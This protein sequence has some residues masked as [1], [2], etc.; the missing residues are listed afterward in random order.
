MRMP[1]PTRRDVMIGALG[2]G[3]VAMPAR[4][5]AAWVPSRAVTVF[6]PFAAGSGTDQVARILQKAMEDVWPQRLVVE[7][8]PGAN[9]S[10]AALATAR[11]AP[12]GHTLMVTTNTPHAA[13]KALMKRLDYDPLAD[14]TPITRLGNYLFWLAVGPQF[15]AR[16]FQEFLTELR[17]RPGQVTYA[18]GNSTGIV[19]SATIARM[20]GVEMVHVPYR[21]TPPAM[22]DVIAGRVD[23]MVVDVAASRGHVEAGRLIPIGMTTR[24]RSRLLPAVPTLHEQGLTG[25][26][27]VAW[28]GLVGPARLPEEVVGAVHAAVTRVWET[29]AVR[30]QCAAIGFDTVTSTPEAFRAFI[31]AEIE[32]WVTLSRA[33]GIEPE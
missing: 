33:A 28:A 14:F 24:Q 32:K 19:A 16:T 23:V 11:A 27:F 25:F 31:A 13:N 20:A 18:T 4:A 22:L 9:G 3:A 7:N 21:S 5:A 26:E 17:R 10:L 15:P 6:V 8:R 1:C 30:G 2:A 12:D 29:E